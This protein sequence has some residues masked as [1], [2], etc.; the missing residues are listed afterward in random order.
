MKTNL[1]AYN[2]CPLFAG[3]KESDLPALLACLQAKEKAVQKE[4]ILFAAG[5]QPEFVGVVLSGSVNIV[6]EDYWGRRAIL[7][8]I[9]EGELFGEAFSCAQAGALPVSVI[10]R[11]QGSVL[12]MD[13]RRILT[14]CPASCAFHTALIQNLTRILANKTISLTRKIQHITKKTTRDKVLSYLSECA[15]SVGENT[16]EIPFNR[17]ELA[18]YLSVERSALSKTLCQMQDEGMLVFHKNKFSLL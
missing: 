7:A 11:Q 12:L 5:D 8:H 17:Q 13:C 16:F 4:E 3:V 14:V 2:S 15:V 1:N 10:A 9:G 18:D 6:Q